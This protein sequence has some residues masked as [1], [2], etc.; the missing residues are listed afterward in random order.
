[1][2]RC[3]FV[4][5]AALLAAC[6]PHLA[7]SGWDERPYEALQALVQADDVRG[8]YAVFDCDNTTVLH[9][10]SHNL[11]I[12]L[13]ENLLFRDA[14]AHNFTD[15]L[16]DPD[17]ILP[18]FLVSASEA[19]KGLAEE[20]YC[21]RRMLD[22]GMSLDEVHTTDLY[23]DYRARFMAFDEALGEVY[24]YAELCYW[25]PL[26]ASGYPEDALR[27]LGA[28]S[29]AYWMSQGRVWKEDWVSPDGRFSGTAEKGLVVTPWM[30][31]LYRTLSRAGIT[32][33]ICSA[34]AE[35]LVELLACNPEY[36]ICLPPEQVFG[37]RLGEEDYPQPFQEGKVACINRFMAPLH[38]GK[39][40]LLV[41]GDSS[42]DMAMLTSY[43]E[44]RVG[45]II[46][47]SRGGD[48]GEL[49]GSDDPRYVSQPVNIP[50]IAAR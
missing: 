9:D 16:S 39:A 20:F 46:D 23:L 6:S 45:L 25:E 24:S 8:G 31:D 4:L 11:T 5:A 43:P 49:A 21:L 47:H 35:W 40:P 18:G 7:R 3:L 22:G 36:G 27:E 26:L 14:P 44:M 42:G 34:S 28:G 19:G 1:M 13:L 17:L 37:I 12:Y 2:K 38:G 10:V 32:P 41:A 50:H 29:I 15:G 30:K 33:Y 48:I